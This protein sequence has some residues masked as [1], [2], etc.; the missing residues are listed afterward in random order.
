MNAAILQKDAHHTQELYISLPTHLNCT[1]LSLLI[2]HFTTS[3]SNIS[4]QF[5]FVPN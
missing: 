5:R 4:A 3:T 2:W 1:I